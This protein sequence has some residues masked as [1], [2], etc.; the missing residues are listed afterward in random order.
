V[1]AQQL[2][3]RWRIALPIAIA[4]AVVCGAVAW[5]LCVRVWHL[6]FDRITL[7]VTLAV[8]AVIPLT[9]EPAKSWVDGDSERSQPQVGPG[10]VEIT[11]SRARRGSIKVKGPSLGYARI[12]DVRAGRDIDITIGE[13]PAG[14]PPEQQ[15][16]ARDS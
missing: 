7:I 16:D 12:T 8:L 14:E 10:G 2:W 9:L 13:P 1:G 3:R 11:R 6:S 4:I 5:L 15:G